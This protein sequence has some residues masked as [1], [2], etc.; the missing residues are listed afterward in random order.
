MF[1]AAVQPSAERTSTSVP[2]EGGA[3]AG[4]VGEGGPHE[5]EG[6]GEAGGA[7]V[8]RGGAAEAAPAAGGVGEGVEGGDGDKIPRIEAQRNCS[9]RVLQHS[10]LPM[11]TRLASALGMKCHEVST[12]CTK[13]VMW[14]Q[15]G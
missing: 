1:F 8:G 5:E 7:G 14:S 10:C 11:V 2:C 15:G 4:V 12:C 6:G 3:A 9:R 13:R